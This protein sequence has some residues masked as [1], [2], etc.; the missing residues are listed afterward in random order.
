MQHIY[1]AIH[2]SALIVLGF[3]F[4]C[5]FA[6]AFLDHIYIYVDIYFVHLGL[7]L[8]LSLLLSIYR[9]ISIYVPIYIHMYIYIYCSFYSFLLSQNVCLGRIKSERAGCCRATEQLCNIGAHEWKPFHVSRGMAARLSL[10]P[11]QKKFELTC[12]LYCMH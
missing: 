1:R 4:P 11:Q 9:S 8:S 7:S 6:I 5:V 2:L 10:W 3:R 12:L